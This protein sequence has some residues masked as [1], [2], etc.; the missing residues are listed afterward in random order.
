MEHLYSYIH[1]CSVASV[2]KPVYSID[3]SFYYLFICY[4]KFYITIFLLS[5]KG[6]RP[7]EQTEIH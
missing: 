4:P 3:L 1:L 5:H 2:V 7:I 6:E